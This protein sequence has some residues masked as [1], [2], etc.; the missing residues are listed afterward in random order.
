MPRHAAVLLHAHAD[1]ERRRRPRDSRWSRSAAPRCPSIARAQRDVLAG[2]E[3][4]LVAQFRRHRE[5]SA[6]SRRRRLGARSRD[7]ERVELQHA[8]PLDALEVVEGLE[9]GVAAVKRLAGRRAE[10][11]LPRRR[12]EPQ[13]GQATTGPRARARAACDRPR[14][15]ARCRR[16]RACGAPPSLSQ[17]L[18]QGGASTSTATASK[19]GVG[20]ARS[21]SALITAFAG[22]PEYVGEMPTSTRPSGRSERCRMTPR[23]STDSTGISGSGDLR[24]DAVQPRQQF[25]RRRRRDAGL[26]A[27]RPLPGRAGMRAMQGL[28]LGEQVAEVLAVPALLAVPAETRPSPGARASPRASTSSTRA[29]RRSRASRQRADAGRG[30]RAVHVVVVE[31]LARERPQPRERVRDARVALRACRRRGARASRRCNAGDT[32]FL[33]RPLAAIAAS[34][35][36]ARLR[37]APRSSAELPGIEQE[38]AHD[39]VAEIAVRLLDERQV[40]GIP[41][42]RAGTRARPRRG[43]G[44]RVRRHARAGGAPGRAGRATTFAS[45]RSSSSAGAWPTHSPSRCASTRLVS[46]SRST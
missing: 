1:R 40:A 44:P 46:A 5:A 2:E 13:R 26:R 34:C 22:Q 24:Q 6:R 29:S 14:P 3:A 20:S 33:A 25:R 18:L 21:T 16:P 35:R 42:P 19:P 8:R 45:P 7:R 30:D 4:E 32:R 17:S 12:V 38:L 43:R 23:S 10:L 39:R 27:H 41:I 11:A 15:A 37:A 9:A 36:V 31:E 28:H